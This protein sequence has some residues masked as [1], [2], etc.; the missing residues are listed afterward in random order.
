MI[1]KLFD[2][3]GPHYIVA[4]MVV[5]RL[6]GG[7]CGGLVI[8]YVNFTIPLPE[9]M[10]RRFNIMAA[11]VVLFAL[12][13]TVLMAQWETRD[14]RRVLRLLRAGKPV[15]LELGMSAGRQAVQFPGKHH[16]HEAFL[17]PATSCLPL[18]VFMAVVNR[19]PVY[20][21]VQ[22][23][24]AAFMGTAV[25]LLTTFFGSERWIAPVTH[26]LLERGVV[27]PFDR[28]PI[29]R[30]GVRLSVCFSIVIVVT[31][32]MISAVANQRAMDIIRDPTR[33]L[34]TVN[35]LREHTIFIMLTAVA[36]GFAFSRV[37]SNSV[38]R[39]VGQLVDA[40]KRVQQGRLDE[41]VQPTGNDEIDILAR[42]FNAMVEQLAQNDQ[43][44]RDLNAN[45][46]QKVKRRTR[47]LSRSKQSLKRSLRKL[48]QYDRLKTEFFSNLSH[49]VRTPLT[50]I[51]APVERLLDRDDVALPH[52]TRAMLGMVRLNAQR[53][54]ELIN[55]LLDF[56]KLEAGRATL[57]LG[58]VDVNQVIHNLVSAATPLAEQRGIRLEM[59]CDPKVP[60]LELD[61]EKIDTVISNLLSN[62][63]KFTPAGGTIRL[64]SLLADDRLWLVVSDTGIGIDPAYHE[65]IFERF[66]QV[67]G[68]SS[69][70]F[71]G[72]GLGLSLAK[73][74]VELHGGQIYLKSA[75]GL[76]SRFWFDLPCKAAASETTIE[77]TVEPAELAP[78][79]LA[80]H[81][82]DLVTYE[83]EETVA[84]PAPPSAAE[85]E[86]VYKVLVVDD[87]PEVRALVSDILYQHYQVVLA[88]DGAE[89]M[90]KALAE[91]PDLIIS[92]VMMPHVDGQQFCRQA[93]ENPATAQIPFVM[94]TAKAEL[95]M[96]IDGLNWGADDYLTKPFEH[97]ELLARARSLIR[98]RHLNLDLDRRNRELA[99]AYENLSQMQTQLVQSEKMSSLGQLVAG[100]AHEINN[101]INVVYNGIKPL[102]SNIRRLE[103]AFVDRWNSP[104]PLPVEEV[105]PL[106]RKLL[107]LANA[108][109]N[110]A[111]RTARIIGDLKTFSHPGKEEYDHFDLH[112]AMDMCVNLLANQIKDRITIAKDYGEVGMVYG[113]SGQL[114]QVF[115]N[116][117]S[118]AQQAIPE[119]GA[120]TVATRQAGEMVAVSIRDTGGGIADDI[121]SRIFDPFFTTKEP[122][123]GTGLGLS[124]SFGIIRQL[125]GA[126]ECHSEVGQ[127]TEF[128]VRFPRVA[129][130]TSNDKEMGEGLG[131]WQQTAG[132]LQ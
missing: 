130:A 104:G 58:P 22:I 47:Q 23:V 61:E 84:R 38:A 122:G 54:L 41:R 125:G 107:S 77:P 50:M 34:E 96:K 31:A 10:Q 82:A 105:E 99:A 57:A 37:L 11:V 116:I 6:F 24:M 39:R 108:I 67:D 69:R 17:V 89:G 79:R 115:M 8:L 121:K 80:S 20:V 112:A 132:A 42:Q 131:V 65:R 60:P 72:T 43:T 91:Q 48:R 9:E 44:I 109:E 59:D 3:L 92:D 101:A 85:G 63:I 5:T 76:G 25:V 75:V 126:I 127:G 40:M 15:D 27:V 120:I 93:K 97:R 16:F 62:A 70:E 73:E 106:F 111:N 12:S 118:N 19:A 83:A 49:E 35:D 18:V 128:I 100:L 33:Q 32:V 56:S 95:T 71:S 113:P 28:L 110:G 103:A 129:T 94:L 26:Y 90:E 2:L 123:I 64:E 36:T 114:N 102:G 30:L 88:G 98:L 55:R 66:V 29:S 53:L 51:L 1:K 13:C 87:S 124:L 14:L 7:M 46:E 81:F 74:F 52:E 45:L 117:L 86:R 119:M 4:M 68:S 21:L 78:R